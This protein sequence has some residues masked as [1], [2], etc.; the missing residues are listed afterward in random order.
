MKFKN[1]KLKDVN[2]VL[3]VNNSL[4]LQ[5]NNGGITINNTLVKVVPL[6]IEWVSFNN[7]IYINDWEGNFWIFN[8]ERKIIENGKGRAFFSVNR[9][10][11][12]IEFLKDE[13]TYIGLISAIENINL[14]EKEFNKYN[15]QTFLTEFT[16]TVLSNKSKLTSFSLINNKIIWERSLNEL[17]SIIIDPMGKPL[18]VSQFSGVYNNKLLCT[19]NNG[20]IV[21]L[22]ANDGTLLH[23]WPDAKLR[24]WL[25]PKEEGSNIFWGLSHQTFIVIDAASET[26]LDQVD[27]TTQLK[28]IENIPAQ[29]PNYIFITT[30]V[31]YKDLIYFIADKNI[32]GIFDPI[33]KEIIWTYKFVFENKYALLK[34]GT[35]NLQVNDTHIYVLDS[36]GNLYEF[37]KEEIIK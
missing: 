29:S 30:S 15:N 10:Y 32:L 14:F 11:L 28:A 12:G 37:A 2:K 25:A 36:E 31:V 20:G 6:Q 27:I 18:E 17:E 19:L 5:N 33:K 4:V 22:N 1:L 8:S 21:M 13:S 23:Y 7:H 34:G 9:K 24:Y 35:E 16:F 3:L 26:I